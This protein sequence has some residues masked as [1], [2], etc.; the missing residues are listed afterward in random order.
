MAKILNLDH[1]K[2]CPEYRAIGTHTSAMD[3]LKSSRQILKK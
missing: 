2:G 1:L 3:T